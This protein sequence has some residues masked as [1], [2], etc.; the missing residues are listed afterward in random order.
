MHTNTRSCAWEQ[1][2]HSSR[3]TGSQIPVS[4]SP[5]KDIGGHSAQ[6]SVAPCCNKRNTAATDVV[7]H[8][9][10]KRYALRI[11]QW[12]D[13]CWHTWAQ[14][15]ASKH[16][17]WGK[18]IGS[19][20]ALPVLQVLWASFSSQSFAYTRDSFFADSQPVTEPSTRGQKGTDSFLKKWH[21]ASAGF[22][23]LD[24][25]LKGRDQFSQ[26]LHLCC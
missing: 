8:W 5:G 16:W 15:L 9:T 11:W 18:G 24:V 13:C 22:L 26:F 4:S 1:Q 17:R 12:W 2:R 20:W 25:R 19:L 14:T 23:V 21:W 6:V 3:G 7:A 10:Q